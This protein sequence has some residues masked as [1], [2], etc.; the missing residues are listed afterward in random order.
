ML[1]EARLGFKT[2]QAGNFYVDFVII[3]DLRKKTA[4]AMKLVP[5]V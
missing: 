3:G 1:I 2:K 4:G 5:A